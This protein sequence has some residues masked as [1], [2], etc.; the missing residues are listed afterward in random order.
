VC[1]VSRDAQRKV[2]ALYPGQRVHCIPNGIAADEFGLHDF[3]REQARAWRAHEVAAGRR[4]IGLFGHLKQKKGGA[5]LLDALRRAGVAG[6]FHLLVVGEVDEA[7][8]AAL[9][10]VEDVAPCTRLPFL[11]RYELLPWYAACDV[12]AIPSHYDGMPNVALEAASLGVPL[13]ASTAGGL[14]DLL[15]DAGYPL[16]FAPGDTGQCMQAIA[17]AARLDDAGLQG[18]G[19]RLRERVLRDFSHASET[20][21]Y[22]ELLRETARQPTPPPPILHDAPAGAGSL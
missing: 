15:A 16:R 19:A 14:A 7:M 2:A 21:R 22:A 3:D 10:A 1:V 9:A 4:V 5:L 11:D 20:A 8:A 6:R 18:L 17:Q 12:V 13:L